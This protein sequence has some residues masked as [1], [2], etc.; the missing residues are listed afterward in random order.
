MIN[1]NIPK[2]GTIYVPWLPWGP[3]W[4]QSLWKGLPNETGL[5]TIVVTPH[6]PSP[7]LFSHIIKEVSICM[8][9]HSV[10]SNS[11]TPWLTRLFCPWNS[12]GNN[13]GVGSLSLLQGIFLTQRSNPCL[14]CLLHCRWAVY[15]VKP[16]GLPPSRACSPP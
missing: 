11:A 8:L 4:K 5:E 1:I 15:T 12:P 10:A 6:T 3:F 16:P 13:N 9:S 7:S 2:R 14:L